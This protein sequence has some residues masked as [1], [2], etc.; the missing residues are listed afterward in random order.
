M[1]FSD[2]IYGVVAT[3]T[4][5]SIVTFVARN[6]ILIRLKASVE[7]EFQSEIASLNSILRKSEE[8]LKSDFNEKLAKINS[9]LR[10]AEEGLKAEINSRQK[11]IEFLRENALKSISSRNF[12]L[13]KRRFVAI[14]A[15]WKDAC[16]I[17]DFSGLVFIR[18]AFETRKS[19]SPED[20]ADLIKNYNGENLLSSNGKTSRL[21]VNEVIWAYFHARYVLVVSAYLQL[22]ARA[23]G[24]GDVVDGDRPFDLLIAAFP[25]MSDSIRKERWKIATGMY[26][27]LGEYL[28]K[29]IGKTLEGGDLDIRD[30][31]RAKAMLAISDVVQSEII[32]QK[33]K[34]SSII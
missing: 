27:I 23:K 26:D 28:L 6:W 32:N 22:Q 17:D 33:Q 14:D 4:I 31:E 18:A 9:E 15:L 12:E 5:M 16:T 34:I 13:D 7:N 2:F 10:I 21:Y 30:A 24:H 20:A 3:G 19:K 8:T 29:E 25:S 11:A 1:N